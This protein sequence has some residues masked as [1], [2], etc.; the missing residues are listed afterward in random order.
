MMVYLTNMDVFFA[1][2]DVIGV[3]AESFD[4]INTMYDAI[5]TELMQGELGKYVDG[6][7][8]EVGKMMEDWIKKLQQDDR[9]K[10]PL[11]QVMMP[12]YFT[13]NAESELNDIMSMDLKEGSK[14]IQRAGECFSMISNVAIFVL[15]SSTDQGAMQDM[16]RLM[17]QTQG[18]VGEWLRK[19]MTA[20]P[21]KQDE[22]V[23]AFPDLFNRGGARA[24]SGG[25][26]LGGSL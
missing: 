7:D 20:D 19:L 4:V 21:S 15:N 22:I 24:P 25:G 14:K 3:I 2:N 26:S 8:Q 18:N 11:V 6:I 9:E 16:Q 5:P 10:L 13:R 23:K 1:T 12:R 17:Q